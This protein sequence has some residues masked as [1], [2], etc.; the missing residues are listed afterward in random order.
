MD[1]IKELF[2]S[3]FRFVL[4]S[5]KRAEQ[6]MEGAMPKDDTIGGPPTR[7]A[8]TEML[9]GL[10][11]WDYGPAPEPEVAEEEEIVEETEEDGVN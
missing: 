3:K 8:M 6:L 1:R 5:A 9:E 7:V 11:D 10:V 4:L 2:D